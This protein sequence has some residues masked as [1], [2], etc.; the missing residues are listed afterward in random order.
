MLESFY[1]HSRAERPPL[2]VGLLVDSLTL[3]AWI[4]GIIRHLRASDFARL[5]LVVLNAAAQPPETGAGKRACW[6][7]RLARHLSKPRRR[8]VLLYNLYT[9]WDEARHSRTL[10]SNPFRPMD[11]AALLEGVETVTLRPVRKGFTDRF[12]DEQVRLIRER[13]LD[14]ILRFGFNIIRGEILKAARCGVWSYHHGDNDYYRGGPP[15]YWE[16]AENNP[17]SGVLLQVLNEELDGGLVLAKAL[18]A[19]EAGWSVLRN[20]EHPYWTGTWL[21]IRKLHE[22]HQYGWEHVRAQ[23]RASGPAAGRRKLYRTPTNWEMVRFLA[24]RLLKRLPARL[25]RRP[26]TA[27]WRIALRTNPQRFLSAERPPDM[28][29]FRWVCPPQGHF[30]ADPFPCA[31]AGRTWLFF[32]D[33]SYAEDRGV[34]ACSEILP[35]GGLSPAREVL[36]RPYHLSYPQV[37]E[38]AGQ[39]YMIPE[40]GERQAVELYRATAFPW[41]WRLERVL[42]SGARVLDPTLWIEE[43]R[44]W[45]FVTL[46]D[47][48][49]AGTELFLF[50]ADSLEGSWNYHPANPISSDERRCRGAGA[51]FRDQGRRIR[52]SQDVTRGYGY[53][54][55]WNEILRLNPAEYEERPL[56]EVLPDWAAGLAGTH[57]YNRT[58]RVEVVDGNFPRP[59]GAVVNKV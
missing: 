53:S 39:F 1:L 58:A 7:V 48:P 16:L 43:G 52:P 14:V 42:F 44:F 41:E 22:L 26:R 18:L 59:R 34:I 13:Q 28:R 45:F 23:A 4:G 56:L 38:H 2:R 31:H 54:F 46:V 50:Y 32:E 10:V 15:H 35:D 27:H 30:Y 11:G 36:R 47:P 21:V 20:R 49:G 51:I 25:L 8:R 29:G 3:P 55:A 12:T 17:V 33:F 40:S 19:T 57:T 37:F 9:R 5:E 24:P 6:L